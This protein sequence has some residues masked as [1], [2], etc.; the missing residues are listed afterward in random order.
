[1]TVTSMFTMAGNTPF[2]TSDTGF[3]ITRNNLFETADTLLLRD[4]AFELIFEDCLGLQ[5]TKSFL[6]K[7]L[8]GSDTAPSS[9]R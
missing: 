5:S 1:M 3:T 7:G 4:L 8:E 6:L 2:H 9:Q